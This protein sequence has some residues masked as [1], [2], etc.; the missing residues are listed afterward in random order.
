MVNLDG[1]NA[2]GR[3]AAPPRRPDGWHAA[4]SPG[5]MLG[6]AP[7]SVLG[8]EWGLWSRARSF[9]WDLLFE[10]LP[11]LMSNCPFS[12]TVI[13]WLPRGTSFCKQRS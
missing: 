7:R 11:K 3:R 12:L 9:R 10:F 6:S 5:R 1:P 8:K 4:L 2:S 13:T